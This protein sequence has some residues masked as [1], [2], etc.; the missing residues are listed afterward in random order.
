ML[1]SVSSSSDILSLDG[2]E[3]ILK[4]EKNAYIKILTFY[5]YYHLKAYITSSMQTI[6][7][8][9]KDV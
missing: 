9:N 7:A 2:A 3:C 6:K 8:E 1:G 4:E 5:Y